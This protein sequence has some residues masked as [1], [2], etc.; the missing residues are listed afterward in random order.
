MSSWSVCA[1]EKPHARLAAL[2]SSYPDLDAAGG[3]LG[4][5]AFADE[6]E[7]GRADVAVPREFAHLM[8]L[9]TVADGVVD[10][11]LAK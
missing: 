9:G 4:I 5:L 3:H 11:G 8:H 7:F 1:K 6:V 10:R 2:S